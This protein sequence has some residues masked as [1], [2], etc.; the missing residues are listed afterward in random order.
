M[1]DD[2][3]LIETTTG[4]TELFKGRLLH[5]FR[6][7]V[8]LPDGSESTREYIRHP[9][10][11]M[12]IPILDDGRLV[13]ERQYRYPMQQVVIEFPAGKLDP[14][15]DPLACA[16]RELLEETGY[17]AREWARAGLMHPVVSYS[18]E[19][20]DMWFARGL[21]LQQT[22]LDDE[23]FLEVITVTLDELLSW[24]R[25]GRVTDSKTLIGAFWLQNVRSAGWVLDWKP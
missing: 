10:A 5:A 20:I 24:C 18:T 15:E 6:D 8:R 11:V 9:G 16:R 23:E 17:T 21:T 19:F 13:L 3:H 25:D 1:S 4:S 7:T 14:G 2:S 12:M 22:R